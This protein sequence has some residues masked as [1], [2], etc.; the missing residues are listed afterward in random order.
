MFAVILSNI[1]FLS[2]IFAALPVMNS[3]VRRLGTTIFILRIASSSIP[4]KQPPARW[5]I[6]FIEVVIFSLF[7]KIFFVGPS[8]VSRRRK[9]GLPIGVACSSA[10]KS[11]FLLQNRGRRSQI[12]ANQGF[13][14]Q[15]L[16]FPQRDRDCNV[17]CRAQGG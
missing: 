1:R 9:N 11:L 16:R 7:T 13:L 15:R 10:A 14:L 17:P 6:L 3:A 4:R 5:M 2:E 12:A 8:N